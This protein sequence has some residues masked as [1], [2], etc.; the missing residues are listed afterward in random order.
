MRGEFPNDSGEPEG[1]GGRKFLPSNSGWDLGMGN[2]P[3][4]EKH[5]PKEKP[6]SPKDVPAMSLLKA[7]NLFTELTQGEDSRFIDYP[8]IRNLAEIDF[9]NNDLQALQQWEESLKPEKGRRKPA[10]LL[11]EVSFYATLLGDVNASP[12]SRRL[13]SAP[14][15][16]A[17]KCTPHS[18][19]D[20]KSP[21]W[22][23]IS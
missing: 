2:L 4:P 1:R 15:A 13:A 14:T 20:P 22:L 11:A 17:P 18:M 12:A 19:T 16:L 10:N 7:K 23:Q 6:L 3:H 21:A 9:L 8:V 5:T